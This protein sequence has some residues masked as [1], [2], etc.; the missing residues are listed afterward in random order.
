MVYSV[1]GSSSKITMNLQAAMLFI[2]ISMTLF[3]DIIQG[4]QWTEFSNGLA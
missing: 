4:Q 2:P 3:T 1:F